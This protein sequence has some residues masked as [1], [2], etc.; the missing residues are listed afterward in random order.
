MTQNLWRKKLHEKW[1]G[2]GLG[3]LIMLW[4]TK[5]KKGTKNLKVEEVVMLWLKM[6]MQMLQNRYGNW[7]GGYALTQNLRKKVTKRMKKSSGINMV[8]MLW[9]NL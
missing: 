4:Q 9:Q 1:K 3:M 8:V 6:K 5:F 2:N 7:Y